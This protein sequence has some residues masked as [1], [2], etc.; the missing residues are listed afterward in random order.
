MNT[1]NNS[2]ENEFYDKAFNRNKGLISEE[3][4]NILRNA[5]VAIPGLGGVGGIY[6]TTLARLG[7]G[8]F[9]IADIDTFSIVN[10]NRQ[11]GATISTTGKEKVQTIKN[12]ILDINPYADVKTFPGINEENID[13]FLN[14]VDIIADG[15]D[16]FEIDVRRMLFR[17]AREKGIP[18]VTAAPIGF[19][20]TLLVFDKDSMRFD[21]YFNINDKMPVN[22]KLVSFA[23][24]LSPSLI[25]R[26]YYLPKT[27]KLNERLAASSVIGTLACANWVADEIYKI[28][29]KMPYQTAPI[30][31]QF[32]PF[33]KKLKRINLWWGNKHPFQ[34]FKKWYFLRM[35]AE[36]QND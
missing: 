36:K 22:E 10:F 17:V 21:D 8:N 27:L 29:C 31:Y 2:K 15:I 7:I 28:L 16:F 23:I 5:R 13:D 11:A 19:G 26:S 35:L 12:M 18:A 9:T 1:N 33:V 34:R 20:S 14:D 24:G 3:R 6:A 25:H 30:S 4:Q 32:D